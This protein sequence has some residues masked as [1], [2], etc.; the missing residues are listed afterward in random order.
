MKTL[1]INHQRLK[2]DFDRLSEI[3]S[4]GDGGVN[5]PALS[6]NHLEARAWYKEQIKADGFEFHIDGA[7]NHS[8]TL[9]SKKSSAQ[10]LLLGSHLDSVP[11]GGR[12]DGALGLIIAYEVLRTIRE[13]GLELPVHLEA[14]DFTDEEGKYIGLLGSQALA[15]ILNPDK[16]KN[17]RG[18]RR[19]FEESLNLAGLTETGILS[20]AR[21]PED[22]A[23][24][25]ELH[26]EQGPRLLDAKADIGIV[27]T[28]VGIGSFK[29]V[30]S[31]RADHA[32]TTPMDARQ[33]A[34]LG[35]ADLMLSARDIVM[36]DFPTCVINF[37]DI[38]LIPGAYNIVPETATLGLE[39]RAPTAKLLEALELRLLEVAHLSADNFHLS[40]NYIKQGCVT[41]VDC[42]LKIQNT[43]KTACEKLDL[44]YIHLVSG[45]GHDTMALTQVCPAGMIFIPSTGGSHNPMEYAD[46]ETCVKGA[47]V[48]LETI[49][50]LAGQIT[51]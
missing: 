21:D 1:H 29:I 39:Y 49:L 47:D 11:L 45:A 6:K 3:G 48:M 46:W 44:R 38:Q 5:R 40:L 32:G 10:T 2:R 24:F 20:S 50:L 13:N 16:L 41:P 8:A 37:G 9:K 34:G 15:G 27:S 30:F 25:I 17:P 51:P 35:A 43:F 19:A 23:G 18:E 26:I 42:D 12:F 22:L 36:R 4:T 31:G 28:I 14:I 7:G 33:D